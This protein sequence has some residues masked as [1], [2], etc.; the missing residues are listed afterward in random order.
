MGEDAY[1]TV[2]DTLGAL[3]GGSLVDGTEEDFVEIPTLLKHHG[4]LQRMPPDQI[5]RRGKK[6]K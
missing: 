4:R 5:Q 6:K 1:P 2:T 3:T